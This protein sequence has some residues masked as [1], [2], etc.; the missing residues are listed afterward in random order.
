M[1]AELV[2][3]IFDPKVADVTGNFLSGMQKTE[4]M[5]NIKR[6][7]RA[8][9]ILKEAGGD[10]ALASKMALSEGNIEG[11]AS[12]LS[13]ENTKQANEMNKYRIQQERMQ[14]IV[15]YAD[16]SG[17]MARS[18]KT[19]L[20]GVKDP[21][22]RKRILELSLSNMAQ[23]N[24]EMV[25]PEAVGQL[26]NM[27]D[28]ERMDYLDQFINITD[29]LRDAAKSRLA[30][31]APASIQEYMFA[32]QNPGFEDFVGGEKER[33]ARKV[34]E[35]NPGMSD[36]EAIAFVNGL[37][38]KGISIKD[39][40]AI[41]Q[42]G[43][44]ESLKGQKYAET[45]GSEQAQTDAIK[46]RKEQEKLA[47]LTASYS[48]VSSNIRSQLQGV[49]SV[50]KE[51]S[52]ALSLSGGW[53]TGFFGKMGSFVPGTQSYDLG[54]KLLTIRANIGFDKLQNM[55]DMSPTG[56]ALG[57][58][59]IQELDALQASITSLEQAQSQKQF[60]DAL[61]KAQEQRR[62]SFSNVRKAFIDEY[63][64]LEGFEEPKGIEYLDA[65]RAYIE[66][67]RAERGK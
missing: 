52:D 21:E 22:Q 46:E 47:E 63:G 7:Q 26:K 37:S 2:S 17:K 62:K 36:S 45:S 48:K 50:E 55:R 1:G 40:K 14:G 4:E 65:K 24:P 29:Y 19:N 34:K 20:E 12:I 27:D 41:N 3:R 15:D 59:A 66:K 42:E 51:I 58:V 31:Q 8:R 43:V 23:T 6:T 54:Q 10:T 57:Q 39:G 60:E 33:L 28:E 32:Q 11:A 13:A 30:G 35:E 53:T 38:K 18:L 49:E 56:G 9:N 44:E 16:V 61:R 64:A 5:G 25:T 67:L